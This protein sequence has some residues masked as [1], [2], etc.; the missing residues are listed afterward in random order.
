MQVGLVLLCAGLLGLQAAID[1]TLSGWQW[2][3]AIAGFGAGMGLVVS[4]LG[5]LIMS[6]VGPE[7]VSESGGVQGA[8]QNLGASLGIALI[9]AVL[10]TGLLNGFQTR[11]RA[12]YAGSCWLAAVPLSCWKPSSTP[13]IVCRSGATFDGHGLEGCS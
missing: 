4:Q 11:V 8:A 12:G 1:P 13:R 10:L 6:A 2:G 5:N 3:L 9:G 7:R